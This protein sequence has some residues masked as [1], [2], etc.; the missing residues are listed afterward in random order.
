MGA[1][2]TVDTGT[3]EAAD[4]TQ[5]TRSWRDR[6]RSALS[7]AAPAVIGY[8]IVRAFGILVLWVMAHRQGTDLSWLLAG[9]FDATSYR[10][11]VDVG[12]DATIPVGP[13]GDL[14]PSNLAFFPA[15]PALIKVFTFLPGVGS[16][17]GAVIVAWLAGL[18]AAW[19]IYL[20]GTHMWNRTTGILLAILWG[21]IPHALV[22]SMG[23]SESLFTAF[24][25]WCL[26]ALL[27]EQWLTAGV[28]CLLAGLTR[29]V[30]V[31]LIAAVGICALVAIVRR[32]G[33]WRPWVAG[34]LA[35]L[36]YVGYLAWVGARLGRADGYFYMQK[37]GWNVSFDGGPDTVR[38]VYQVL[39]QR[40]EM[41][42]F[43]VIV[44][45]MFVAVVLAALLLVQ[46][47]PLPIVV[48]TV[49][50]LV[51]LAGAAGGQQGKARYLIPVFTLLIPVAVG[52]SKALTSTKV[53]V[54]V[55]LAL[56]SAWYGT[57]LA[58]VWKWSP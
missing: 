6:A 34:A 38:T 48:Y 5:P 33:G 35:P 55:A 56:G 40:G 54:L 11:I 37:E 49:V 12:Y 4:E 46:R 41:L 15:F 52:L 22:E 8:L 2:T 23:Y 18:A 32:R 58:L 42:A 19:G 1:L 57:Y 9:R 45:S 47:P 21:V 20:V 16:L 27:R 50:M 51:F 28:L 25:A 53:I 17:A 14:K 36:G 43:Y 26:Y 39:T 44:F 13:D 24:A 7:A 10:R 29:P 31:A 3:G 30:A